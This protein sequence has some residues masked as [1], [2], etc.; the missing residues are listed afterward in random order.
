[1]WRGDRDFFSDGGDEGGEPGPID[2][3]IADIA[4]V[5]HW[6]HDR[7]EAMPLEDLLKWQRLAVDRFKAMNGGK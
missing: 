6:S 1:V 4:A 5:F 7:L 3:A 2:Q